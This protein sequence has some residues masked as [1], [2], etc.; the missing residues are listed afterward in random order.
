MLAVVVYVV[1]YV[2]VYVLV[3]NALLAMSRDD[4]RDWLFRLAVSSV[5]MCVPFVAV[6]WLPLKERRAHALGTGGK[7]DSASRCFRW[8]WLPSR[9]AMGSRGCGKRTTWPCATSLLRL[10][11]QRIF[12]ASANGS[13]S[14]AGTW[15]C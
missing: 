4:Q 1:V 3:Y 5:A 9:R 11:T 2:L 7:V 12:P 14:I 8:G 13:K 6:L 15:W 10:L